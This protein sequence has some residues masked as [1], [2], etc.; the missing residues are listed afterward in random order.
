MTAVCIKYS[1]VIVFFLFITVMMCVQATRSSAVTTSWCAVYVVLFACAFHG[2]AVSLAVYA[3]YLADSWCQPL[4]ILNLHKMDKHH[5]M[6]WWLW[7]LLYEFRS[8]LHKLYLCFSS[9][10]FLLLL[11]IVLLKHHLGCCPE[12]NHFGW[13]LISVSTILSPKCSCSLFFT[14]VLPYASCVVSASFC[15]M[16]SMRWLIVIC[17][18]SFSSRYLATPKNAAVLSSFWGRPTLALWL[19]LTLSSEL[20]ESSFLCEN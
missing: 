8:C 15:F 7:C 20:L 10:F 11:L 12:G 13:P 3:V 2:T 6:F 5:G 4:V 9:I 16:R 18:S 17:S 19:F 1:T 14:C